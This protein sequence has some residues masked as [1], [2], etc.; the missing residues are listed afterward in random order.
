MLEKNNEYPIIEMKFTSEED[1]IYLVK[2]KL[3]QVEPDI[4]IIKE[5]KAEG[6]SYG[7]LI[8]LLTGLAGWVY[9][10]WLREDYPVIITNIFSFIV[11]VLIII[12][13]IKYKS[14]AS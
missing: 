14:K 3:G 1:L 4:K 5:K 8:I 7:M 6:I 10:G 12:F 2:Q 9:Y 11:N 13:S